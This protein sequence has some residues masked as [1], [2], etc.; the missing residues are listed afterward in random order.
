MYHCNIFSD[1]YNS[2]IIYDLR[3]KIN[4][5]TANHTNFAYE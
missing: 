4:F 3:K 2:K 5:V 1:H